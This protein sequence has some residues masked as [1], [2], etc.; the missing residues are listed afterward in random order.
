VQ[1]KV[2]AR[3]DQTALRSCYLSEF[4]ELLDVMPVR[5]HLVH[6]LF[7]LDRDYTAAQTADRWEDWYA[8]RLPTALKP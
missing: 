6:A 8:A 1:S 7:A 5:S 3:P 2:L 4:P